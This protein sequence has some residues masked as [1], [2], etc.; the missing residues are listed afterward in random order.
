MSCFIKLEVGRVYIKESNAY[1]R[2][3]EYLKGDNYIL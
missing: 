2:G 3:L 1:R